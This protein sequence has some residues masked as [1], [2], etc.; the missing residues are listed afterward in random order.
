MLR[1]YLSGRMTLEGDDA[2]L[3]P[4]EFPGRQGRA[5]F[6]YLVVSRRAPVSRS[7]LAD[8]LW[9][10]SPPSSWDGALSAIV[11]KLRSLLSRAGVD[12]SAVLTGVSGT[13]EIRFPPGTW[14]DHEAAEDAIHEAEAALDAGDVV[15]AYGPSAVARLIARRPFLPGE[16]AGWIEARRDHLAGI[17]VRALECRARVYL[18]NDEHPLAVEAA[19]E[20]VRL[21]PFRESGYRLL[22]QAHAAA[23]NAAEAL[24]VYDECRTVIADELGV[25]P[26]AETRA[27]HEEVLR[28]V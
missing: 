26:S 28:D 20:M 27:V 11:S 23:G 24:R 12:G 2:L 7:A 4:G 10:G 3:G 19:R 22:M 8:A 5:A 18:W 21:R 9:L 13:Y 6:A 25:G 15:A 1:I 16:E 14:I 17:L